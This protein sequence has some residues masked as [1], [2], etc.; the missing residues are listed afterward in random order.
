M[1]ADSQTSD[2]PWMHHQGWIP[3]WAVRP[4]DITSCLPPAGMMPE[5]STS[6]CRSWSWQWIRSRPASSVQQSQNSS[7]TWSTCCWT[8]TGRRSARVSSQCSIFS[9]RQSASCF[10]FKVFADFEAYVRCQERVSELYKV[11]FKVSKYY[12]THEPQLSL[13]SAVVFSL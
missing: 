10:R 3:S 6:V 2:C 13:S 4:D 9:W 8:T 11:K 7:K 5:S 1:T 12:N